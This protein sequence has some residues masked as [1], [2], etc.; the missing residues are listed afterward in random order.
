[1]FFLDG[2]ASAKRDELL[3]LLRP[4]VVERKLAAGSHEID[5]VQAARTSSLACAK[6]ASI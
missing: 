2:F 5:A 6:A 1:M 4:G 3:D